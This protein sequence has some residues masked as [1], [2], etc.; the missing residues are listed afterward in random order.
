LRLAI[1]GGT[2]DP[3]HRA[4]LAVA[5]AAADRCALDRILFVPAARPPHKA[6]GAHAPYEDRVRMIELACGGE[7]RFLASRLEEGTLRSYSIHTIEKLRATLAPED[8]LF[9]IIGA[10][11][12]A[13]VRTWLRWKDVVR[14]V[15][16]IVVSRPGHA[17]E[18]PPDAAVYR[19]DNLDLPVSS[20]DIRSRLAAGEEPPDVPAPV[21]S[22]IRSH[23]L[24]RL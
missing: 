13:E 2:F 3:V 1:Y 8:K 6:A 7:P 24:Y 4:H 22:Y 10:D 12:F 19:L 15:E 20:S 21:L 16:F 14:A 11:A 9:F 5:H 17:Y 23:R 18:T